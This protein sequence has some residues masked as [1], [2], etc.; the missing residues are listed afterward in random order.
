MWS[1]IPLVI[2]ATFLAVGGVIKHQTPL[3]TPDVMA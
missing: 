3:S 2:F 1:Q